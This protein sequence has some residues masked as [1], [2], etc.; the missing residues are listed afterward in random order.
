MK[1]SIL[2][3]MAFSL[4]AVAAFAADVSVTGELEAKGSIG[5]GSTGGTF[6]SASVETNL[7][8]SVDDYNSGTVELRG[9]PQGGGSVTFGSVFLESDI[10]GALGLTELVDGLSVKVK[11]G[12]FALEP[13]ERGT[14]KDV[15]DI[16]D[17]I[18]FASKT[19]GA[20]LQ[21]TVGW[22]DL[23]NVYG[24]IHFPGFD[25]AG[26]PDASKRLN[27]VTGAYGDVVAGPGSLGYAAYFGS[28]QQSYPES[29]AQE[30]GVAVQYKDVA[31]GTVATVG[32]GAR[33]TF[34]IPK[35]SAGD[36]VWKYGVDVGVD[37]GDIVDVDLDL[38][39]TA[40]AAV[41]AFAAGVG[42]SNPTGKVGLSVGYEGTD[43]ATT[44]KHGVDS[45]VWAKV[46]ATTFTVGAD[47]NDIAN[48]ATSDSSI[49]LTAYILY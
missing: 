14:I 15:V 45:S 12:F 42:V 9:D 34:Q 49:Y 17:V 18:D 10:A 46:G 28:N 1:I 22:K 27:W 40:A 8:V 43:V 33:F 23:V 2:F 32:A 37:I 11:S 44:L 24:G 25:S 26:K 47:L 20:A 16:S 3:L 29:G 31:I 41:D 5:I 30:L 38:R 19:T 6:S 21:T 4:I 39:G 7:A 48:L 13:E 35:T 36:A